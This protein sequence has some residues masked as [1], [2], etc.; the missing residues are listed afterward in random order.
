ME[1]SEQDVSQFDDTLR[2]PARGTAWRFSTL[3]AL[4]QV[5]GVHDIGNPIS[6][7]FANRNPW[8]RNV[9]ASILHGLRESVAFFFDMQAHRKVLQTR[10]VQSQ[11]VL[12]SS[13]LGEV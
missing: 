13:I 5:G 10:C 1:G 11:K 3:V 9:W 7:R 8:D 2:A 12:I 4:K 6:K